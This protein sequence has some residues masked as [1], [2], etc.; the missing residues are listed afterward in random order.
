MAISKKNKNRVVVEGKEYLWWVFD[1]HDQ[2]VFCGIQV[3]IVCSD[4]THY[5]QY[6]LQQDADDLKVVVVLRNE[7]NAVC[8]ECPRFE[9]EDGI[10][11]KTGIARMVMWCKNETKN[12]LYEADKNKHDSKMNDY[13][14]ELKAIKEVMCRY[15]KNNV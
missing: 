7:T 3:K 5:V 8:F 15:K 11:T 13:Q 12:K 9:N 14:S 2:G 4:Q 1:E 6:G 10:I